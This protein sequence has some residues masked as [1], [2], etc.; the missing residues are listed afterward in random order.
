ML[1]YCSFADTLLKFLIIWALCPMG[2]VFLQQGVVGL[3]LRASPA[4]AA[5]AEGTAPQQSVMG[6]AFPIVLMVVIFYFLIFRPQKKKQQQHE[7]M[8]ASVSRGDTVVSAGG[9]FGR[10]SD[11]LDDSYIIEISEGVKVRILKASISTRRE[12]ADAKGGTQ[13]PRKKKKR[14]SDRVNKT[15]T[16]ALSAHGAGEGVTDAE[17]A[18]LLRETENP[19]EDASNEITPEASPNGAAPKTETE[20]DANNE[21]K[22]NEE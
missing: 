11:I 16:P 3:L 18:V 12:Q 13:R 4:Y 22:E 5:S 17:S 19:A 9:F 21:K 20:T 6:L 1:E 7:K 8:L 14:V 15:E 2:G 10:V